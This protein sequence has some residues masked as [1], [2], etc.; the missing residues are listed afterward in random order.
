VLHLADHLINASYCW[1]FVDRERCDIVCG[2]K[3][4][5]G[6]DKVRIKELLEKDPRVGACFQGVEDDE[7]RR[8]SIML[9]DDDDDEEEEEEGDNDNDNETKVPMP[10]TMMISWTFTNP[11]S[12]PRTRTR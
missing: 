5:L 12:L 9:T 10:M 1:P 6:K 8:S 7:V 2:L 11:F 3:Q 4:L